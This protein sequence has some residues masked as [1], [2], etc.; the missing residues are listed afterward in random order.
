MLNMKE[1][2]ALS[3]I[4]DHAKYILGIDYLFV[5]NAYMLSIYKTRFYQLGVVHLL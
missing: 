2:V 4:I 3:T 5:L 1:M